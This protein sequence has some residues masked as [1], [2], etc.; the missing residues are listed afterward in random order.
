MTI[1]SQG[2]RPLLDTAEDIM[3]PRTSSGS[4][5]SLFEE[6][7]E[8]RV[9]CV[10]GPL[11]A[12]VPSEQVAQLKVQI[13][14]HVQEARQALRHNEFLDV[15][16]AEQVA[17][18]LI[19]LLDEYED[20]PKEQQALIVGAARYFA[21]TEDAEPDTSSL[22]GFDDDVSVLNSVLDSLGLAERKIEL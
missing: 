4:Q 14:L 2:S 21:Q 13:R 19:K 18:L 9:N 11:C 20:Y 10:F 17:E 15:T 7:L 12:V 3:S 6:Q 22:L 16:T 8:Y 1:G 5:L